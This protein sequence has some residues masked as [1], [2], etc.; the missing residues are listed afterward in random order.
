M[1]QQEMFVVWGSV[2]T[3]QSFRGPR[4]W[5]WFNWVGLSLFESLTGKSNDDNG[6]EAAT[7]TTFFCGAL[8]S[9]RCKAKVPGGAAERI[10]LDAPTR[11][12]FSYAS[13]HLI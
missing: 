7:M 2:L 3:V 9:G 13:S 8:L 11:I 6:P 12:L 4:H 5:K 1:Q 10:S